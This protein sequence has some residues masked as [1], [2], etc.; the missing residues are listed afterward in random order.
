MGFFKDLGK[1]LEEARRLAEELQRQAQEQAQKLGQQAGVPIPGAPAQPPGTGAPGQPTWG[2]QPAQEARGGAAPA[3]TMAPGEREPAR[4]SPPP[5]RF[6]PDELARRL[7]TTV[8]AL[9]AVQ[10]VY[11]AFSIPKRSGGQR[12]ILAPDPALRSLQRQVL[13]RVLGRLRAHPAAMG[14][15]RGR[16]IVTH[17][18][19]HSGRAVVVHMDIQDFFPSTRAVT[20]REYFRQLGWDDA[21]VDLLAKLTVWE[22][23]LPQGAPT[24]PRLANLV[25]RRLDARLAGKAARLGATYTRYADDITFSFPTAD[26]KAVIDAIRLTRDTVAREGYALH[27]RRKLHVRKQHQRQLVTG[28]VVNR[29]VGLPRERRRWLRA[30]EHHLSTGKPATL[31]QAQLAGWYALA[32]MIETQRNAPPS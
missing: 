20:V 24:S 32:H 2:G 11:T 8:D 6:G 25:N 30:V 4:R 12:R 31:T 23:S 27:L 9:R 26:P 22:G 18:R 14:F 21:A 19:A 7:G 3:P 16:S 17:A 10:P 28:L 13:R 29:G 1:K 5:A 15:E